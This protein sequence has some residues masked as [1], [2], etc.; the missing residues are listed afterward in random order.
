M[1]GEDNIMNSYILILLSL[2]SLDLHILLFVRKKIGTSRVRKQCLRK[3]Q[4]NWQKY[5]VVSSGRNNNKLY[6]NHK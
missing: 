2:N 3:D 5:D 1:K 4:L 6:S